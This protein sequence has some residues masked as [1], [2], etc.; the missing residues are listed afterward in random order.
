MFSRIL[1]LLVWYS[2][3][4]AIYPIWNSKKERSCNWIIY[5]LYYYAVNNCIF[6]DICIILAFGR[7]YDYEL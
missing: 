2:N 4:Y 3:E 7:G 1:S 6:N 5:H